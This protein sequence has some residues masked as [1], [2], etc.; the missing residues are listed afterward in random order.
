MEVG[1]TVL[2]TCDVK[3]DHGLC[4]NDSRSLLRSGLLSKSILSGFRQ[5]S[6]CLFQTF[7]NDPGVQ[8]ELE[9]DV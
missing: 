6:G 3:P 2:M 4:F 5:E 9:S 1:V 7:S 8:V